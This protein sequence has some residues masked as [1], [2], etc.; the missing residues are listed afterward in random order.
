MAPGMESSP[1]KGTGASSSGGGAPG[2][3][4]ASGALPLRERIALENDMRRAASVAAPLLSA[5]PFAAIM[6]WFR[7]WAGTVSRLE[8]ELGTDVHLP[9]GEHRVLLVEAANS[10]DAEGCEALL[11]GM[12]QVPLPARL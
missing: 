4:R 3:S 10:G 11:R 7:M 9:D 12:L 2:G 8:D 6:Q 5:P 1:T